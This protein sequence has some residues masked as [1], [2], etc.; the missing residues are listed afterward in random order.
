MFYN[1]GVYHSAQLEDWVFDGE[2][3][4]EWEKVDHSV[5]LYGWGDDN[6][7]KFW[8]IQNTWGDNWGE[9]GHFRIRRGVDESA[10][11]SLAEA[12]IPE[13]VRNHN[14]IRNSYL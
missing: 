3:R 5:L 7:E 12:A 1:G 10:I 14:F 8:E 4:P 6:G 2:T 9:N 11:E 13:I